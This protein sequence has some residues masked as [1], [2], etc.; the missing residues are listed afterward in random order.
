MQE[1]LK[2]MLGYLKRSL[3]VSERMLK[4]VARIAIY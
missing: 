4:N 3:K 2:R 1:Y